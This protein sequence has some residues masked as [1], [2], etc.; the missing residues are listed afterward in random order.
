MGM[1]ERAGSRGGNGGRTSDWSDLYKA[2]QLG[3]VR[4]RLGAFRSL[5]ADL[6]LV[7]SA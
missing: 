2:T 5:R 3:L 7:S 1:E 6:R 4:R